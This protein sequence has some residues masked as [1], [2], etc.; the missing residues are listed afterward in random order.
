MI[1]HPVAVQLGNFARNQISR[2]SARSNQGILPA[3]YQN[4]DNDSS[5]LLDLHVGTDNE[6]AVTAEIVTGKRKRP[7]WPKKDD[8][9]PRKKC[10]S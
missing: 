5:N 3:R 4:N 9:V 8:A 7:E 1:M 10:S 6:S 2:H